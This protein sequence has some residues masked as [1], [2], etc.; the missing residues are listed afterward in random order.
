LAFA[1]VRGFDFTTQYTYAYSKQ[2]GLQTN[3]HLFKKDYVEL[4]AGRQVNTSWTK[5]MKCYG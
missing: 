4:E 2:V 3:G 5:L 1:S